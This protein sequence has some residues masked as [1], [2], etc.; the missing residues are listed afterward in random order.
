[1]ARRWVWVYRSAAGGAAAGVS[2]RSGVDSARAVI[3]VTDEDMANVSIA[4]DA[5]RM[6]QSAAVVVRVFDQAL[7]ARLE[8][9]LGLSRALSTSALAAPAFAAAALGGM[10]RGAFDCDGQ[11]FVIED[12]SEGPPSTEVRAM[13]SDAQG[14]ESVVTASKVGVQ[15]LE[16]PEC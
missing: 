11:G 10:V 3:A 8:P 16:T 13:V 4:L 14:G 2:S 6:N 5:R 12:V 9:A 1:M 7:A 15:R